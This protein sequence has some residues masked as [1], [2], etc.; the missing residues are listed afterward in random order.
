MGVPRGAPRDYVSIRL[1]PGAKAKADAVA[2]KRGTTRSEVIRYWLTV[3]HAAD[4]ELDRW[5]SDGDR[6][7]SAKSP[8]RQPDPAPAEDGFAAR[9]A[10]LNRY[11]G[12]GQDKSKDR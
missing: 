7:A 3:G 5:K 2:T 6:Q 12:K 1:G 10:R 11:K 8:H 4:P 9:H